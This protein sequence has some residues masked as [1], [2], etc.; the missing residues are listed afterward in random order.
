MISELSEDSKEEFDLKEKQ[1]E[2]II[3]SLNTLIKRFKLISSKLTSE[4][5]SIKKDLYLKS[6]EKSKQRPPIILSR[7]NDM[8][9]SSKD[10]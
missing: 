7:P 3:L 1:D 9:E 2:K 8:E 10:E 4:I 6:K 5:N